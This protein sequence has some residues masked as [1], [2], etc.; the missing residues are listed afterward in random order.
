MPLETALG[1]RHTQTLEVSRALTVPEV[2]PAFVGF[3]DMPP[4]FA[5]A[6]MVGFVEWTCV[7]AIR[8]HLEAGLQSVGVHIDLSHVAA[9]PS[10]MRVTATVEVVAVEGQR[11]RFKVECHD[12][13][14]L[15]GQGFHDRAVIEPSRF[16]AKVS[17]RAASARPT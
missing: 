12:A 7:E 13:A 2:S 14:G 9:T 16:M 17:A 6:F 10:G 11:L 3:H 8:T 15:I 5:T 4:V 1:V